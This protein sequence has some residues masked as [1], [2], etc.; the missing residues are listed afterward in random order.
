MPLCSSTIDEY[1]KRCDFQ[2]QD[3]EKVLITVSQKIAD[4]GHKPISYAYKDIDKAYFESL[5]RKSGDQ[6][7]SVEFRKK[8]E[9]DLHYLGT[10]GLEDPLRKEI[11]KPINLLKYGHSKPDNTIDNP[12]QVNVIMVSGDH[13]SCCQRIALNTGIITQNEVS[14]STVMTGQ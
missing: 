1:M 9:K 10:F 7:E 14:P 8:F 13:I 11:E 5:I 12:T 3:Q 2:V 4:K 6:N